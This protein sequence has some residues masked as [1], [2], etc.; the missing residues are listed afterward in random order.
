MDKMP[1]MEHS[2][3]QKHIDNSV[4]WT[5]SEYIHHAKSPTW[6]V[7]FGI[8][9]LIIIGIAIKVGAWTF[10]LLAVVMTIAL[11]AV[12]T[13]KPKE[14][15]YEL[16]DVGLRINQNF[17]PISDFRAFGVANDGALYYI[18]L[19]PT[20]RFMPAVTI[21]FEEKDGEQIVDILG[22]FLPMQQ[23]EPDLIDT[24]MRRIRF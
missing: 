4:I 6:Y 20:K 24:F 7:V 12:A 22:A 21:Y 3:E 14:M 18:T 1:E 19:I 5:A 17:Y 8:V 15:H 10:V 13:R 16:S 9:M 11:A 2:A 23:I